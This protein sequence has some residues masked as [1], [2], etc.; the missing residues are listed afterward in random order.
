MTALKNLGLCCATFLLL[1]TAVSVPAQQANDKDKK[2]AEKIPPVKDVRTSAEA[3]KMAA[4]VDLPLI[5]KADKIVL[6][7]LDEFGAKTGKKV[8]LDKREPIAKLIEPLKPKAVAEIGAAASVRVTFYQGDQALRT[9]YVIEELGN[10]WIE[11]PKMNW[12]TGQDP[13]L[14]KA[15]K[16][17][18]K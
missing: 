18:L 14:W 1:A 4:A 10:W 17:H 7:Q 3:V 16:P 11:R 9:I 2:N 6:E 5:K 8:T 12:A 13:A 15:I